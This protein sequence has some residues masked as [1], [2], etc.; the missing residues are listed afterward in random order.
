MYF[1]DNVFRRSDTKIRQMQW[2]EWVLDPYIFIVFFILWLDIFIIFLFVI[3]IIFNLKLRNQI[4]K[5]NLLK[6]CVWEF[7]YCR[8]LN[9]LES[10]E[11]LVVELLVS[12]WRH[13]ISD[14]VL[15]SFGRR[16]RVFDGTRRRRFREEIRRP[17]L[18]FL[19]PLF[20]FS[21][22]CESDVQYPDQ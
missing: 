10:I 13:Y 6:W 1:S 14:R 20:P 16:V 21:I 4:K 15:V 2:C 17:E 12:S 19:T 8:F 22:S 3:I 18:S 5:I 7:G 9:R 11:P